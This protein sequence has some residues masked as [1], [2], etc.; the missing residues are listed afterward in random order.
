MKPG[1]TD[2][3]YPDGSL[4]PL[5]GSR[6]MGWI[7]R[8]SLVWAVFLLVVLLL[9]V[10]GYHFSLRALRVVTAVAV[11]ALSAYI[12]WYGLTHPAKRRSLSDAFARGADALGIAFFRALPGQTGWFV[13]ATLLVIGY[14]QLEARALH[15]QARSLD[16]SALAT[17]SP[18]RPGGRRRGRAGPAAVRP[19]LRRAQ[20]PAAR[21]AGAV[22]GHLARRQPARAGV[23]R[24]GERGRRRGLA[25]AIINF[26]GMLW[27]GPRRLRVQVWV[28]RTPGDLP[29]SPTSSG[30]RSTSTT[31]GPG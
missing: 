8:T 25:G 7:M 2:L 9:G 20:V 6:E 26:F 18:A 1:N 27:P 10:V 3:A 15:T 29:G 23:H 17:R 12:P 19:A 22:A 21:G 16:T 4:H 31:R 13:I 24:R 14:R 5:R 11:I 30:S 28:E